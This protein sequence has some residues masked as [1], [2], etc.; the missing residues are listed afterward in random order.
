M[1]ELQ[2]LLERAA[3]EG[4][5]ADAHDIYDG[6]HARSRTI[7]TRRR[8]T[9]ALSTVCAIVV[10]VAGVAAVTNGGSAR[11][12]V[13]I[14]QPGPAPA[15]HYEVDTTVLENQAHGPELCLGGM[16]TSLPPQCGGVPVANWDWA[17]VTGF[18]E[19][20]GTKWGFFHLVGTYDGTSFT[21]TQ[22]A[23]RGGTPLQLGTPADFSTPCPTPPGGWSVVDPSKV[24][25]D[26]YTKLMPAAESQPDFGGA[27]TD[28]STAAARGVVNDLTHDVMNFTF[29]GDLERHKADLQKVW[30]GPICVS[31]TNISHADRMRIQQQLTVDPELHATSVFTDERS[32]VVTAN[33][34]VA[35]PDLQRK[36]DAQFGAGRVKL[37][38]ELKP[39]G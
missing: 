39:I 30:G 19:R 4:S 3:D 32:G 6:A 38:G 2:D 26:D 31:Q 34:V 33:V 5:L 17:K 18:D 25:L 8:V 28:Q 22:P 14:S 7:R 27:W 35:T 24:S 23:A 16:A 20:G 12:Q 13:H 29:T 10:V 1:N 15:P 37:V 36:V 9:A 11:R 21:L